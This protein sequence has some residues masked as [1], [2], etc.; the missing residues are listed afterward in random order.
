M[1]KDAKRPFGL[2]PE[3]LSQI[4]DVLR[5]Q[6]SVETA[7]IYGSRAKGNYRRGSDIDLFLDGEQLTSE[8]L[9]T[10]ENELDDLF[11]SGELLNPNS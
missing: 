6:A 1:T 10:I 7:I 5:N 11:H 4:V 8:A 9:L 2:E 3:T